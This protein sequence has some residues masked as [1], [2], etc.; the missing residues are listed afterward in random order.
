L[1][2]FDAHCDV[3][4]KLWMDPKL[5]FNQ[6]AN[7]HITYEKLVQC[8]SKVQCF[9]IYIPE[10]VRYSERF[11]VAL[12]MVDLFYHKVLA[13]SPKLKLVRTREDINK[14]A[15]D[16]IG[17]ILTLEGCDAV[18][19]DLIRLKTLF[20]L[21]V[22]SIGLTW[23]YSNDVADGALESRGA[24]LSDFGKKVVIENNT[25][26]AWTDVSHLSEKGFWDCIDIANDMIAS[27]SNC[28]SI[29]KHPRNL[30]DE[31]IK[32]LIKKDGMVGITFVPKFL[33]NKNEATI[34]DVLIHLDHICSL[35]GENNV[36]FGSDFDGIAKTVQGLENYQGYESLISKLLNYYSDT[37]VKKFMFTNFYNHL[38]L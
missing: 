15:R 20:R 18:G 38:P 28:Y 13:S 19:K 17:A 8:G 35:G 2:I 5:S 6:S 12:E 16:E 9:A 4:F 23:N 26:Y 3:L 29:C 33:T 32:A 21:G 24:G 34:D 31:Q 7:L 22:S 14:L 10:K 1:E 27:H 25:A 30:K 11:T 37:D 36:G